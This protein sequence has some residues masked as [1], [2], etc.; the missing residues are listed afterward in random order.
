[1]NNPMRGWLKKY[2]VNNIR[3]NWFWLLNCSL[4]GDNGLSVKNHS[5][6]FFLFYKIVK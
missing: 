6:K 5:F 1:M 2:W 3:F 4:T